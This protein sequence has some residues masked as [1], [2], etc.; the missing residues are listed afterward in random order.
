MYHKCVRTGLEI[1]LVVIDI[2]LAQ[3]L[4]LHY[5]LL[6]VDG[7]V[8]VLDHPDGRIDARDEEETNDPH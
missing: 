3:V 1:G 5:Q 8:V 7:E 6:R 2:A 4:V